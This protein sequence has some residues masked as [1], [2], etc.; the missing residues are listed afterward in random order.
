MIRSPKVTA[1]SLSF[2]DCSVWL[3]T[4]PVWETDEGS[5]MKVQRAVGFLIRT[6]SNGWDRIWHAK[7]HCGMY[8]NGGACVFVRLVCVSVHKCMFFFPHTNE[9][10]ESGINFPKT[11]HN[12]V[13][14]FKNIT[15][16]RHPP[17]F[18]RWPTYTTTLPNTDVST[19]SNLIQES[20]FTQP[21]LCMKTESRVDLQE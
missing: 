5:T 13:W 4:K 3:K 16:V 6:A 9:K 7:F 20:L 17:L 15:N 12:S 2:Q 19:H 18:S 10:K 11:Y 21:V 14:V 1:P 8:D